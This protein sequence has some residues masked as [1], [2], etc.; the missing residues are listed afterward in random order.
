MQSCQ[1]NFIHNHKQSGFSLIEMMVVIGIIAIL[2]AIAGG[3][4][5]SWRENTRVDSAKE[6]VASIL[7]QARLTALSQRSDQSVTF[8]YTTNPANSNTIV[9][10]AGQRHLFRG[11]VLQDYT[12][13]TCSVAATNTQT[14]N[15]TPRGTGTGLSMRISSPGTGNVFYM[16]VNSVTGRVDIR[17]GCVAGVCQ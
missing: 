6:K 9:D 12:C 3:S 14:I 5:N 7:Q 13:G 10:A 2:L 11:I 16:M 15:F 8:D 17:R 4:F 1:L